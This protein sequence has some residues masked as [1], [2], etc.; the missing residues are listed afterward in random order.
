MSGNVGEMCQD[1]WGSYK[2]ESQVN[3]QGPTEGE[4]GD[5]YVVRG[6]DHASS[7]K[8]CENVNRDVRVQNS[9]RYS[10]IGFRLALSAPVSV[11]KG[12]VNNDG[13]VDISDIVATINHI[14]GTASYTRADVNGDNSVD[15]SDIV[16]IINIIANG[17]SGEDPKPKEDDPTVEAGWCPDD[18]HPHIIDMGAAGKWACCNVGAS[19]PWEFGGYYAWG[20]SEEK[21]NYFLSN[22]THCDGSD[23]TM[24]NL[25]ND[26]AGTQYDVAHVKWGDQWQMPNKNQIQLLLNNTTRVYYTLNGV[27]GYKIKATNGGIIF[28]PSARR[29]YDD[30]FEELEI[31]SYWTSQM[32]EYS[33]YGSSVY[34]L[35]F[36]NL[37]SGILT[38]EN[39]QYGLSVRPISK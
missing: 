19:A 24:H 12:D 21:E 26:I 29:H 27:K 32:Y 33:I 28:M 5:Y 14:A 35:R 9:V 23:D 15:I 11:M 37:N 1:L 36:G 10:E 16:A 20:E 31:G 39:R 30:I 7:L 6:G 25:G 13:K 8:W 22:Y 38:Q 4:Y 3:P 34:A 17:G 2:S 18:K